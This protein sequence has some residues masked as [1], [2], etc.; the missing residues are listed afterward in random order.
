MAIPTTTFF[1]LD[2]RRTPRTEL[3]FGEHHQPLLL[4]SQNGRLGIVDKDIVR[5][6]KS[7]NRGKVHVVWAG[8]QLRGYTTSNR[9]WV[10]PEKLHYARV[11]NRENLIEI[12]DR[13]L[14][15]NLGR[16]HSQIAAIAAEQILSHIFGSGL[17]VNRGCKDPN[18]QCLAP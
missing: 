15:K 13:V 5:G 10:E 12:I 11:P 7:P 8:Q 3:L 6:P 16:P 18:C 1:Y 9:E 4:V 2:K 14:K 17:E